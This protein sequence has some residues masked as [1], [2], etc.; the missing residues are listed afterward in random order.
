MRRRVWNF[1][2]GF[3]DAPALLKPRDHL[4]PQWPEPM[5]DTTS[6]ATAPARTGTCLRRHLPRCRVQL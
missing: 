2:G 6:K 4:G 3:W 5:G 1:H